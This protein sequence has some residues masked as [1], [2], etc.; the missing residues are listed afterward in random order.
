[1][2][3]CP[4]CLGTPPDFNEITMESYKNIFCSKCVQRIDEKMSKSREDEDDGH[5]FSQLMSFPLFFL[6]IM[7]TIASHFKLYLSSR[8]MRCH[9]AF[10]RYGSMTICYTIIY[11]RLLKLCPRRFREKSTVWKLTLVVVW[12]L[13]IG[14]IK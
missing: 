13:L 11:N 4:L 9:N 2:S 10:L 5:I 7:I 12:L 3:D 1:M 6:F 8:E 14:I